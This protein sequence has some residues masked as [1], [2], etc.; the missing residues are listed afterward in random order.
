MANEFE[1][2]FYGRFS[3]ISLGKVVLWGVWLFFC[4][5]L[6]RDL[7][8]IAGIEVWL[9]SIGHRPHTWCAPYCKEVTLLPESATILAASWLL[10]KNRF[11][12]LGWGIV[13][14]LPFWFV[15]WLLP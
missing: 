10:Y 15:L 7:A 8:Q 5:H 2:K 13:G 4:Y 6:L 3:T 12:K 9:T 14:S 1:T 11:G